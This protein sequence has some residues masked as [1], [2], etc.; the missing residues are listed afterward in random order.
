MPRWGLLPVSCLR[1]CRQSRQ[2]REGA[3]RGVL[4]LW[5]ET[6]WLAEQQVLQGCQPL[7][8]L[9]QGCVQGRPSPLGLGTVVGLRCLQSLLLKG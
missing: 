6:V 2:P 7:P 4:R 1:R 3:G 5:R 9:L 8:Q